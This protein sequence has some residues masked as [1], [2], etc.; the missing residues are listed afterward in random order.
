M[1]N[2]FKPRIHQ[3]ALFGVS[4]PF[5]VIVRV[6]VRRPT[7]LHGEHETVSGFSSDCGLNGIPA[8]LWHCRATESHVPRHHTVVW[9]ERELDRPDATR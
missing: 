9:V 7:I 6:T 2:T 3:T 1:E 8:L 5:D 4:G